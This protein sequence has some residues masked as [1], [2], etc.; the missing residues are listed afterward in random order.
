MRQQLAKSFRPGSED[1][2]WLK[3]NAEMKEAIQAAMNAEVGDDVYSCFGAG[4]QQKAE[5]IREVMELEPVYLTAEER[6]ALETEASRPEEAA[7]DEHGRTMWFQ[8]L[9]GT[10]LQD[11]RVSQ[12]KP[13]FL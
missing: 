6:D 4:W 8:R 12:P 3:L 13:L 1:D 2:K 10:C 5:R 11:L 7:V 9:S